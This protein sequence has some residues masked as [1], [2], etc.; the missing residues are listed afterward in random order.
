MLPELTDNQKWLFDIMMQ[1]PLNLPKLEEE[2]TRGNY[3]ADDVSF[4]AAKFT[5]E[6]WEDDLGEYDEV[7]DDL[8]PKSAENRHSY[9]LFDVVKLLLGHGLDPNRVYDGMN[10]IDQLPHIVNGYVGADTL[11]LLM[12][13][14]VDMNLTVDGWSVFWDLD[15]DVLFDAFNQMDRVRYDA[16][17]HCWFVWLGYGARPKSDTDPLTLFPQYHDSENYGVKPFEISDLKEH[18]NYTFF[19]THTESRGENWSLHIVDKRTLWEVAR[20]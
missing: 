16:L 13:N 1:L 17:V 3:T 8:V 6:C 14:G 19:L 2:L 10:I 15:Y 7:A 18:R 11:A 5:D 12:E 20:L 9:Y 4:V